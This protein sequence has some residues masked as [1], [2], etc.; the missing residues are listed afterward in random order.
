MS[1]Q[2]NLRTIEDKAMDTTNGLT[3]VSLK[4][5]GTIINNTDSEC[6]LALNLPQHDSESGRWASGS[7]G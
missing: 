6:T 7:S 3:I 1:T 4:V 2:E 5:G